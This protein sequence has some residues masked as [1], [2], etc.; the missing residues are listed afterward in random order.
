MPPPPTGCEK[1]PC[2]A[3]SLKRTRLRS[4][5][6]QLIVLACLLHTLS[7]AICLLPLTTFKPA[8]CWRAEIRSLT[9]HPHIPILPA[10]WGPA[11]ALLNPSS[12]RVV[13][14]STRILQ[15]LLFT[16]IPHWLGLAGALEAQNPFCARDSLGIYQYQ[17]HWQAFTI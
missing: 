9:C 15:E 5:D 10:N 7:L 14:T 11:R 17:T 16:I 4:L 1:Q 8:R 3:L 12:D 13:G 6:S 2:R